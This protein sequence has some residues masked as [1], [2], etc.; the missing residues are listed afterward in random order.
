MLQTPGRTLNIGY[1]NALFVKQMGDCYTEPCCRS[2]FPPFSATTFSP[3]MLFLAQLITHIRCVVIEY[4]V[5]RPK[6]A[7]QVQ[8]SCS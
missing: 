4:P 8:Q 5:W 2:S 7:R 1:P 3:G 6:Y